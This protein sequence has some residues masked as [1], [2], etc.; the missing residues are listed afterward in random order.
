MYIVLYIHTTIAK[1]VAG[2]LPLAMFLYTL[3]SASIR[4]VLYF[5]LSLRQLT[6]LIRKGK[7]TKFDEASF[8]PIFN[9][10]E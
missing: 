5:D 7:S 1:S 9:T 8:S 3:N 10:D 4:Y 6:T 2:F